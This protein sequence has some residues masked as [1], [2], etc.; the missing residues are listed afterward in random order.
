MDQNL[1]AIEQG[2]VMHDI[3]NIDDQLAAEDIED[4]YDKVSAAVKTATEQAYDNDDAVTLEQTPTHDELHES[5]VRINADMSGMLHSFKTARV[6]ASTDELRTEI[7]ISNG[8]AGGMA[9]GA[10]WQT[11]LSRVDDLD[12]NKVEAHAKATVLRQN[13]LAGS[14]TQKIETVEDT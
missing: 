3:G 1:V 4:L 5:S 2:M 12:Y 14:L 10:S 7:A 13:G 9:N 6:Q 8:V 11:Q